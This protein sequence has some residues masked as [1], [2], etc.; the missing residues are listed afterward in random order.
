LLHSRLVYKAL[1]PREEENMGQACDS[2]DGF[3]SYHWRDQAVAEAF[4]QTLGQ[5]R[6][7]VFLDR[8]FLILGR[9][10]PQVL[11]EIIASYGSVAVFVG[12]QGNGALAVGGIPDLEA[13]SPSP[14]GLAG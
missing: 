8:W 6:L 4:A 9:P 10:W 12:P 3:L 7:N 14:L 11:E 1:Q 13:P 5:Q 2:S